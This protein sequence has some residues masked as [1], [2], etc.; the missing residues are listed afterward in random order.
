MSHCSN[1][2]LSIQS[3]IFT[4]LLCLSSVGATFNR[5]YAQ[6]AKAILGEITLNRVQCKNHRT[7]PTFAQTLDEQRRVLCAPWEQVDPHP[8][9]QEV[10]AP[11]PAVASNVY[12]PIEE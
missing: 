12:V 1:T 3:L 11:V 9:Q 8:P 4:S 2:F 6:K 10:N 7:G 5:H